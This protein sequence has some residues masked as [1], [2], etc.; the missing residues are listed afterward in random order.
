ML[1]EISDIMKQNEE[2]MNISEDKLSMIQE[3]LKQVYVG[4]EKQLKM[5]SDDIIDNSNSNC[6]RS[7]SVLVQKFEQLT[8]AI[9]AICEQNVECKMKN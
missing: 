9:E 7:E 5:K 1:S 8:E 3:E 4:L 2:I 6:E